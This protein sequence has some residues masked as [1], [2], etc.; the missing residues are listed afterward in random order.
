MRKLSEPLAL[1]KTIKQLGMED[2]DAIRLGRLL[3]SETTRR[4]N[5]IDAFINKAIRPSGLNEFSLGVQAFLRLYVYETRIAK[6]WSSVDVEDAENIAGLARSILGWKTLQPVERFLGNLLTQTPSVVFE[7]KNDEARIALQT[8]QPVWFVEYCIRIFG[9]QETLKILESYMSPPPLYL[10]LNL[11]KGNSE[12]TI[13]RLR[14]EGVELQETEDSAFTYR[15]VKSE[16]PITRTACFQEGAVRLQD[17]SDSFAVGSAGITKGATVLDACCALG[18]IT[19]QIA[20]GLKNNGRIIS[21]DYSKRR[22]STWT[23]EIKLAGV[24]IA[25]PVIAD[26]CAPLPLSGEADVIFLDPPCT[27]TGLFGRLPSLKWR[28]SPQS[29]NRMV[30]IQWQMLNNCANYLRTTGTLVYSTS[31]ITIEENEMLIEK[32][33]KWHSEF[34]L[35]SISLGKGS[36]G[37]R[38]LEKCLRL[39]PHIHGCNGL[40]VAKL[41]KEGNLN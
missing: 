33:L 7:G 2:H 1:T 11:L 25:E 20:Q 14:R 28:L 32:F 19:T 29:V 34:S 31:S 23:R 6:N 39:Y 16:K 4:K 30:D 9:R 41:V 22:M 35:A 3:V 26:V 15:I 37:L 27:G 21:L 36:P 38:G 17:R 40:F 12:E 24:T 10:R 8:F 5:F 13:V 18:T